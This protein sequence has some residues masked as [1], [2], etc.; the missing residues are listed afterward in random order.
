MSQSLYEQ[1]DVSGW[2]EA[3]NL[4]EGHDEVKDRVGVVVFPAVTLPSCGGPSIRG[5]V[6]QDSSRSMQPSVPGFL[7]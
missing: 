3:P 7:P 1:G 2:L 6:A 4:V 5:S